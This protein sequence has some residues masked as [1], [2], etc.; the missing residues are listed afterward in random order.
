MF[1]LYMIDAGQ[2]RF[3]VIRLLTCEYEVSFADA[4]MILAGVRTK[5]L[6]GEVSNLQELQERLEA[7]GAEAV[8]EIHARNRRVSMIAMTIT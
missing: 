8:I 3:D 6:A 7:M 2:N 1:S 5:V 4:K